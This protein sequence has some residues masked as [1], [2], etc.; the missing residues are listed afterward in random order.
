MKHLVSSIIIILSIFCG[1][2]KSE[3]KTSVFA[4]APAGSGLALTDSLDHILR[5]SS[6]ETY[7]IPIIVDKNNIE[8]AVTSALFKADSLH[9]KADSDKYGILGIGPF[10][11]AAALKS[12]S[13]KMPEFVALIS[14]LGVPG[15]DFIYKFF[16]APT[17][18]MDFPQDQAQHIR[19]ELRDC[20][21]SNTESAENH[22]I[23]I[24]EFKELRTYVPSRY[25][26]QI[27]CPVYSAH[28]VNDNIIP[29]F[30]NASGI[31]SGVPFN[32]K[33]V[34][35]VFPDTG[36]ALIF[37][38]DQPYHPMIGDA[39]P[40]QQRHYNTAIISD[41]ISWIDGLND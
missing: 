20:L 11:S 26:S 2:L 25:L 19:K 10:G 13:R 29:W 17:Y 22:N 40:E 33:S 12:T 41:L 3:A 38:T 28:G 1:H 24:E 36:Y 9:I 15:T 8:N 30:E 5:T 4:F 31:E 37:Q 18:V 7:V 39:M 6:S 35:K 23:I 21:F 16:S 27:K 34:F 14:A 32:A